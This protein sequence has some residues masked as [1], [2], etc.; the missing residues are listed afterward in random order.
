MNGCVYQ[1]EYSAKMEIEMV[2]GKEHNA[3]S[4]CIAA[5]IERKILLCPLY[6]ENVCLLELLWLI[7]K[8][9]L[10]SAYVIQHK[11]F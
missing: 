1:Q 2:V 6:Q 5:S 4:T 11:Y 3:N 10:C 9:K 7:V 8:K